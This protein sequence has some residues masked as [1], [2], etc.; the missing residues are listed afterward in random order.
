MGVG[1][2]GLVGGCGGGGGGKK[3]KKRKS[4]PFKKK[5]SGVG[6]RSHLN[7]DMGDL[8]RL[9]GG[10]DQGKSPWLAPSKTVWENYL[11]ITHFPN[12]GLIIYFYP[13]LLLLFIKIFFY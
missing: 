10:G 6:C 11:H 1:G 4:A 12:C 3:E 9:K 2:G 5:I 13:L 8:T 7:R